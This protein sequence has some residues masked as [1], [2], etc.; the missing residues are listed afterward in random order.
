[1]NPAFFFEPDGYLL[2]GRQL[3]G[4]H[5]AGNG[6]LRAAVQG[7]GAAPVTGYV[8]FQESRQAF[9]DFVAEADPDAPTEIIAAPR[10]D[11]V[12]KHGLL[13]RPDANLGPS[14]RQRLRVGPAAYSLCGVTHTLASGETLDALAKLLIEPVMAWDAVVCTSSVALSV[15]TSVFDDAAEYYR[16]RTGGDRVLDRPLTPIIPLGVHCGDFSFTDADRETARSTLGLEPGTVAVLSAGR[17]SISAKANPY[18]LLRMLQA[19]VEETGQ[20]LA[21]VLAGQAFNAET[22]EVFETAARTLCPGVRTLFVDGKDPARYRQAWAAADVFVSLSDSIQETFGLTPL[23]AMASGLPAL[24][25]DWN[26]YKDTVRDGVDGF[27][28]P[29]WTP[30]PGVGSRITVE[31]ELGG[32]YEEYLYRSGAAVAVDAGQLAARLRDLVTDEALRRRLGAAGRARARETFDW[33]VVYRR[34]QDLWAEQDAIRR[35][36]IADPPTQDWLALAPRNAVDHK[37]PFD[38]F[39]SFPTHHVGPATVVALTA[40]GTPEAYRKIAQH[41]LIERW[42]IAPEVF[43]RVHDA[44]QAGPATVEALMA[45]TGFT[46]VQTTEIVAR[47]AKVDVVSLAVG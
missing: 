40:T 33:S 32:I 34:Y 11:L 8:L 9:V 15:V 37:G 35:R 23:E 17:L 38:R 12:A 42:H 22:T 41:Q 46:S 28:I 47:L 44:L 4:R 2:T 20:S 13:Y 24:V 10:L 29:T 14:A 18:I 27:R 43:D 30:P 7:R 31:Y 3:M 39:A 19:T 6:F 25:S 1:L 26:G 5:S 21:L 36:A 16:W 45:K